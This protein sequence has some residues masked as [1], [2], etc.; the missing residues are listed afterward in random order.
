MGFHLSNSS[1]DKRAWD[2]CIMELCRLW[3]H[4]DSWIKLLWRP[5]RH[6]FR[7][8]TAASAQG[9]CAFHHI[10]PNIGTIYCIFFC[11]WMALLSSKSK[12]LEYVAEPLSDPDGVDPEAYCRTY[13][14]GIAFFYILYALSDMLHDT[15]WKMHCIDYAQT[16]V[17]WTIFKGQKSMTF[18]WWYWS[19]YKYHRSEAR[20]RAI[21]RFWYRRDRLREPNVFVD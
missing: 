19:R 1:F 5:S 8:L 9:N 20:R 3:P 15:V 21:R 16:G 7:S 10:W 14:Q 2:P 13:G 11:L 17:T 4:S 18:S 12:A 6:Y